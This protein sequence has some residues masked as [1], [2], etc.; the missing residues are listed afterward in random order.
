MISES[1]FILLA[2]YAMEEDGSVSETI[3]LFINI[4]FCFA[5]LVSIV[6]EYLT[7][8]FFVR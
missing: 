2:V 4:C 5:M 1:S 8:W 3:K 7:L 6:V